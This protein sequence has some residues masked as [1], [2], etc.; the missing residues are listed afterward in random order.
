[1]AVV[2]CKHCS[3][4]FTAKDSAIKLGN[5]KYC[6]M[7][8][9]KIN[10]RN[11]KE[12]PCAVCLKVTYKQQRDLKRSQ[13]GNYFCSKSCQTKWRNQI[14]VGERHRGYTTG[15][16]SYREALNR[17]DVPKQ[18]RLCETKDIRVLAVHHVDKN[19]HNNKLSNLAWLCHNCHFLVHHNE[20]VRV[21]FM[22]ALAQLVEH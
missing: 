13:S 4:S 9:Y 7:E 21:Q 12:I 8:C 11:G 17:A 1:M 5:G 15:Q 6:S 10:N 19:R 18:C 14:Y 22:A 20:D 16:S 2:S 3:I